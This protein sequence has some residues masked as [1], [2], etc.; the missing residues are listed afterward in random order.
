MEESTKESYAA[1]WPST[2]VLHCFY[3]F[4]DQYS[5]KKIQ[6]ATENMHETQD[7]QT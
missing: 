6:T 7:F 3:L 2:V 4:A 5:H 1:K